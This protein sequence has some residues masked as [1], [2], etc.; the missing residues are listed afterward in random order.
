MADNEGSKL[1]GVLRWT[2][3]LVAVAVIYTGSVMW[4]RRSQNRDIEKKSIETEA[5]ADRRIVEKYGN[6]ELKLLSFY[7]NPAVIR[8]GATGLLC[9]G[10]ANASSLQIE[11][12]VEPVRP[13]LSR[14]VNVK[15]TADTTYTLTAKNDKGSTLTQ[16][17]EVRV[18]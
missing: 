2:W 11:P 10:V 12:N 14:C 4:M 3:I 17:V 6:G 5:E 13:S 16:T 7:A 8:K 18:Q 9:Y 1:R 15:P